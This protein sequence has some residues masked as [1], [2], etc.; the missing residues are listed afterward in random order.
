MNISKYEAGIQN[1]VNCIDHGDYRSEEEHLDLCKKLYSEALHI[2][3]GVLSGYACYCLG[4]A[5]FDNSLAEEGVSYLSKGIRYLS[6]TEEW[7]II[8]KSYNILALMLQYQ[9]NFI[10][11]MDYFITGIEIAGE[12]QLDLLSGVLYQNFSTLCEATGDYEQALFYRRQSQDCLSRCDRGELRAE[13]E[14]AV[15][16]M[17]LRLYLKLDRQKEADWVMADINAILEEYP[18][19][20]DALEILVSQLLYAERTGQEYAERTLKEKVIEVFYQCLDIVSYFDECMMLAD[21]LKEKQDFIELESV[22]NRMEEYI[23]DSAYA[24]L[25]MQVIKCRIEIYEIENNEI[26]L[27]KMTYL[28]F[29]L[30]CRQQQE[31]QRSFQ[32]VL[33]LKISLKQAEVNNIFL[34]AKADMDALTGIPNRRKMNEDA[35]RFFERA[36]REKKHLGFEMLDI[37]FFKNYNDAYGHRMGDECII[38]LASALQ[39]FDGEDQICARYGGDE[40]FIIYFGLED[41]E[42]LARCMKL[43]EKVAEIG[44]RLGLNS[45]TISQG[46]ANWIPKE[47]NRVWDFTSVADEALYYVKR[48]GR[49]DICLIH[50]MRELKELED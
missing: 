5:C 33:N 30:S 3:D 50:G 31:I 10:N 29:Q 44:T 15:M 26:E 13:Y 19:Y 22:L 12:H 9:G 37:D 11:A 32:S 7:E 14:I 27:S 4:T 20:K 38:H 1:L 36:V 43:N 8:S 6:Q 17:L 39:E 23:K 45:F 41:D 46:I 48:K 47:G 25:H 18:S 16:A 49:D 42:I 21:Y 40:F 35:D 24:E 34:S 28:Y 2:G